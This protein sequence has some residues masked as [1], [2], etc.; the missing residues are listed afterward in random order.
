MPV[1]EE[2]ALKISESIRSNFSSK[3]D[4]LRS[5]EHLQI[6]F[7]FLL[8]YTRFGGRKSARIDEEKTMFAK[9]QSCGIIKP[10][11]FSSYGCFINW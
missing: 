6:I 2:I 1:K 8:I 5:S 7:P 3:L 9:P 4:T 10:N 11:L